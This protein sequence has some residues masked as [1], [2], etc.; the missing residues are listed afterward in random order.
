MPGFDEL[1]STILGATWFSTR[2]PGMEGVI[3][4]ST[5]MLVLERLLMLSVDAE[6]SGEVRALAMDAVT[7]LHGWLEGKLRESNPVWRAHFA[8]ARTLIQQ[9]RDN[10]TLVQDMLP[11]TVP[12][13]SPIGSHSQFD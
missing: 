12:P 4:R 13:G 1:T 5:N 9:V 8:H 7:V 10:P 11:V 2:L 6:A 3:Q